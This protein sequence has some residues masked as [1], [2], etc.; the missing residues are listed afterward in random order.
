MRSYSYLLFYICT[1]KSLIKDFDEENNK[2]A[3]E[4]NKFC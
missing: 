4:N 2:F 1:S 3:E